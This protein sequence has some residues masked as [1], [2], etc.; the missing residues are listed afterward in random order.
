MEHYYVL[1][2]KDILTHAIMSAPCRPVTKG[3]EALRIDRQN[4][5]CQGLEKG[6]REV[7]I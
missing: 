5:G 2:R 4:R 6:E 3:H 7:M 1:K